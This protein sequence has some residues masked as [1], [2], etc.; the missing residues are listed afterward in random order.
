VQTR[1]S[2]SEDIEKVAVVAFSGI[3]FARAQNFAFMRWQEDQKVG[4][5][6]SGSLSSKK[7]GI[8]IH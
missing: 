6:R 4:V 8:S 5:S 3:S 1:S 2:F 7:A